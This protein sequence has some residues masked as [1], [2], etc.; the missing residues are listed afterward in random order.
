MHRS[1]LVRQVL[2][3]AGI[4]AG[5]ILAGITF[6]YAL[7]R[8]GLAW[9]GLYLGPIGTI[10]LL[11]SLLYSLRKRKLIRAGSPKSLLALHESLAWAGSLC[12]VLHSG[13]HFS[14]VLPWL[15][16]GAMLIVVAS[17]LTGAVLLRRA[18]E[19]RDRSCYHPSCDAPPERL[20]IDHI[21]EHAKGGPT[22][23]INGRPACGFHNRWR[24]QHPG[25]DDDPDDGLAPPGT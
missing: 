18:I 14:A 12:L 19:V 21:H 15:A 2:P 25:A 20:E 6:D 1:L 23:Q 7:H 4:F 8:A 24:N 10:L 13:I 11:L 17:G 16:L 5:L 22:T 9:V 3:S